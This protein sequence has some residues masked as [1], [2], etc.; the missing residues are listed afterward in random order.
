MSN[1]VAKKPNQSLDVWQIVKTDIENKILSG[2]YAAGSRL[3]SIRKISEE[4]EVGQTTV[5]KVF[6]VLSH[7]GIID[8]KRGVGY[9][10]N[11]YI[12]ERLIA[13]RKRNLEKDAK[14]LVEE[15]SLLGVDLLP[16]IKRLCGK[17]E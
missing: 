4:Y 15:A 12:R 13:E 9:F 10:V 17:N 5:Q 6:S 16:I 14:D 2:Y 11:A 7:E 8:S 1:Y 3:P